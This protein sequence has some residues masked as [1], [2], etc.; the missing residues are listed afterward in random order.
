MRYCELRRKE[1]VNM[2]DG[3]SLGYVSDLFFDAVSGKICSL[4]VP[5]S[6]GMKN[7]LHPQSY[8]IPWNAICKLG[9]DVVLVD[10]NVKNCSVKG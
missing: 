3:C 1:V 10:I 2:A 5:G 7:I 9:A 4:V 8:V 6:F